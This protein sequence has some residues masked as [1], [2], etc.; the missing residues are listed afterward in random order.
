MSVLFGTENELY[1][2][3]NGMYMNREA[4]EFLD[5]C[6]YTIIPDVSDLSSAS[7][8]KWR[9]SNPK[10]YKI[11]ILSQDSKFLDEQ[12]PIMKGDTDTKEAKTWRQ[13]DGQRLQFSSEYRPRAR[14]LYYCYC[15]AILICAYHAKEKRRD[16]RPLREDVGRPYWGTGGSYMRAAYITALAKHV[17]QKYEGYLGGKGEG[18]GSDV[19]NPELILSLTDRAGEQEEEEEK[20][21]PEDEDS[22]VEMTDRP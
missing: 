12:I 9:T 17:G 1:S 6:Y 20:G 14:Y 16:D 15:Y 18:E 5:K 4:K 7:W 2:P 19:T 11:K 21:G 10:E 13:L 8:E 3:L 22:D